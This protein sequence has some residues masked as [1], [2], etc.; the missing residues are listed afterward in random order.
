M[1][2]RTP[3]KIL[4]H[5]TVARSGAEWRLNSHQPLMDHIYQ[6]DHKNGCLIP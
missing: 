1:T 6:G 2:S 3:L 5:R 4:V